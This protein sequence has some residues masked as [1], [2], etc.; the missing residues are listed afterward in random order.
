MKIGNPRCFLVISTL[1]ICMV[2]FPSNAQPVH[3]LELI[4]PEQCAGLI[5]A[6]L[7][8]GTRFIDHKA[9]DDILFGVVP[10]E[11]TDYWTAVKNTYADDLAF[12][13]F[14]DNFAVQSEALKKQFSIWPTAVFVAVVFTGLGFLIGKWTYQQS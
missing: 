8:K 10:N 11:R 2:Q 6:E 5:K 3:N 13:S 9:I 7:N 4:L 12:Q 14:C 1:I